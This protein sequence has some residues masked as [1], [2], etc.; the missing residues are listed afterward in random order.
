MLLTNYKMLDYLLVRPSDHR[1][2]RRNAPE[3]LKYFVVDEL[4]TFDGAS[5]ADLACLVRRI[6]ARVKAPAGHLCCIGTS[7]TLGH[8][9]AGEHELARYASQLFGE[10]FDDEALIG[11]Q[12]QS[13]DEFLAGTAVSR[14]APPGP[15][16]TAA[17]S[18]L[19]YGTVDDYL[20]AQSRLWFD[21]GLDLTDATAWRI[22]LGRQIRAHAFFRTLL[23]LVGHRSVEAPRLVEALARRVP[24][25]GR[26]PADY[27]PNLIDSFVALVSAARS[28]SPL[29][30][31]PLVQVRSQLW[32]REL[33]RMV[34]LV[35]P[36][37]DFVFADDLA[38]EHLRVSLPVIHCR[39]CGLTGWG[40]TRRE[41]ETRLNPDLRA[42]YNAF[43]RFSPAVR[44]VF[45]GET[46]P[47]KSGQREFRTFLCPSCLTAWAAA[48]PSSCTHCGAPPKRAI[49]A[50]MPEARRFVEGRDG[51]AGHWVG[52]HDCPSCSG[53]N[54]LTIFGSRAASLTAVVVSQ[55]FSSPFNDDKKLLAFSDSVQ[56]ASHGAGFFKARTFQFN[57][58]AALQQVVDAEPGPVPLTAVA[59]RFLEAWHARLDEATFI[60][61]FIAPDMDWLSD[62][63]HLREHGRL[64][65]GS[66]LLDLVHRRL[67]WEI[68]SE[69]TFDA[70]IGRTLE[71]TGSSTAA[72]RCDL[73]DVAV[74]ALLPRLQNEIGPLRA[75]DADRLRRFVAGLALTLKNRGGVDHPELA[76]YL[77]AGGNS[78]L[79]A[80]R[81]G[82]LHMPYFGKG[83]RAPVFLTDRA[84]TRL[85]PIVR[86]ASTTPTWYEDWLARTL[87]PVD[88]QVSTFAREIY[89]AI[90]PALVEAGLLFRR[91]VRGGSAWGLRREA[92]EITTRV[93]EL[94]CNSCAFGI[95]VARDAVTLFHGTPCLRYRCGGAFEE[96]PAAE[97]YYRRLYRKGDV[98]RIFAAEHSGLLDRAT[99]ERVEHGFLEADR[100]GDPNLLSCTPT[101][102]MGINIGDLSTL[103]LCSIPPKPSHYLQR[104]G[105]AGRRDG[106]AFVVAVANGRPHDLFFYA[107]PDEMIQGHVEPPGCFLNA[108]AVLE[109]QFTGF[110]FD[111]W[112]ESGLLAGALPD[113]LQP[114]IE[115][116][117]QDTK[118]PDA[119][120][121][122]LLAFF[123]A[124]RTM[125]EQDFVALFGE[126][127][128]PFARERIL[129]YSRGEGDSAG[130][131]YRI[132]DGL[133]GLVEQ[134]RSLRR[135]IKRLT[136]RIADLE[137]AP[138]GATIHEQALDELRREK[139]ALNELVRHL[140]HRHVLNFFTDEGLLPNYAFP[141]SGVVLQ[142][143]IYRRRERDASPDD[144]YQMRTYE[145]QRP[146]AVA[147]SE[148]APANSFFAEGRKL[149][150]DQVNLDLSQLESW[151]FC[152]ACSHMALEGAGEAH[153]A[154]PRCGSPL[155]SDQGQRRQMLRLRQVIA[156]SS[157]EASRSYDEADDREPEFYQ[158]NL[159]VLK[160]DRD[161]EEAWYLDREEVPFGFEFYRKVTLREVNFGRDE[162]EH[163]RIVVAGRELFD[164]PF[165]ICTGCGKVK[166]AH[167]GPAEHGLRHGPACPYRDHPEREKV[168]EACYI[169]RE[170]TSEAIRMLL[171]VAAFDVE[172]SIASFVAALD[173]G[174]RRKFRGD[175]GHL[176]TTVYDEPV[177]GSTVRKRYLVLYDGVPGGT[178]YLKELMRDPAILME[179]FQFAW[180]VLAGCSCQHDPA[181]D[182][183]Y[184]CLLAYRGR[185]HAENTSRR[186]A[187]QL[188]GMLLDNRQHLKKTD[189]IDR[190]RLNSLLESELEKR[191][192][193][194]VRRHVA[195]LQAAPGGAELLAG[196]GGAEPPALTPQVVRGKPG[197]FL[198]LPGASWLVEPQVE[199]GP[200]DGVAVS[201]RADFVFRPERAWPGALP[202]AV[203]TDGFEYHAEPGSPN[204]RIGLDTA[205]RLA[206]ARSGRFRVWSLVW[207]DVEERLGSA[208][209][210]PKAEPLFEEHWQRQ[211]V[212]LRRIG[213]EG[214]A[215]WGKLRTLGSFD[216]L[217]ELLAGTA[218]GG[219][220]DWS[221]YAHTLIA[222]WLQR[223]GGGSQ[224]RATSLREALL[225]P[226]VP[227]MWPPDFPGGDAAPATSDR[228]APE[229]L[230][231]SLTAANG[232]GRPLAA[233]LVYLRAADLAGARFD[234]AAISVRLLDQAGPED[235][236]AFR[237]RSGA[238]GAPSCVSSIS[239][240]LRGAASG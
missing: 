3:T 188:L 225:R 24:M 175:P 96:Q 92:L 166:G 84:G 39:E 235:P 183:C 63:E 122:N 214:A 99:R 199:L 170:V 208:N 128:Q 4:H 146:A 219:G 196:P 98:A 101:L 230:L 104:V 33:R 13:V 216:L 102:E 44:F 54:S 133:M 161:I 239:S 58:R 211:V 77:D 187:M 234:G 237:R 41:T 36:K 164:N 240:S 224:G 226:G 125:L 144:R 74:D 168:L 79:L 86:G 109:R 198:R 17:L 69:Y 117:D 78:Y 47:E 94:R 191:F 142:S 132:R 178:G 217:I 206:I 210:A 2:W 203:F 88:P 30:P 189:R 72:L 113:R 154:C 215:L 73:L 100:P 159:F 130:L 228:A 18:P 171:P 12:V 201:S 19:A 155:W 141:E 134:R 83:S 129:A 137:K 157:E 43:F 143:V 140:H 31:A 21:E 40:A 158:K 145:Y 160:D 179:V 28:E 115:A 1:L 9:A 35:G 66:N 59:E 90:L 76:S 57:L 180:D 71:K 176:L 139:A 167:A 114:V 10:P 202:I 60:A 89:E 218:V 61:T 116:L 27:L 165:V 163:G 213:G 108:S 232:G 51:R 200:A 153:A 107:E 220:A 14:F 87:G 236:A 67:D 138:G 212:A 16:Q 45:P 172:L 194:A 221:A 182:G 11:E 20:Q 48:E 91:E 25:S 111:R 173:L 80:K 55:L 103:A 50:G 147:I 53:R 195:A 112:V 64:P 97:D 46:F 222:S 126:G 105:R 34:G 82:R 5:G 75:L 85:N 148:L 106:N 193:E 37:P 120:P 110:V 118:K 52:T 123:Q 190:I 205:Q 185:H 233:G 8:E 56:D 135:A 204:Q 26:E 192:I 42:F 93:A 49:E 181:K 227:L 121:G 197:W 38:P 6:K 62:Y 150:I 238:H 186:T 207:D 65:E 152:D 15:E 169:Y 124:H 23:E 177:P 127:L 32:L 70:R 131:E 136:T 29:G 7:A 156:T 229:Y 68:W 209:G 151:R 81:H 149:V 162:R 119:F 174:L 231:G 184:R 95:S 223:D 22:R